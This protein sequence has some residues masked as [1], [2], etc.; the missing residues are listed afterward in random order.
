MEWEREEWEPALGKAQG[1]SPEIYLG[2]TSHTSVFIG[3]YH[4]CAICLVEV[5]R[6]LFKWSAG[7]EGGGEGDILCIAGE[8]S[9]GW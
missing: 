4:R 8:S 5:K 9:L 1:P 7:E 3:L 2:M 6:P